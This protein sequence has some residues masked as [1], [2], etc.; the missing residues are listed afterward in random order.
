MHKNNQRSFLP[1]HTKPNALLSGQWDDWLLRIGS[2]DKHVVN[3]GGKR[4]IWGRAHR[5]IEIKANMQRRCFTRVRR[6]VL[7]FRTWHSWP[8]L[9]SYFGWSWAKKLHV[10]SGRCIMC[11]LL[12]WSGSL[13]LLVD[14][15]LVQVFLC[16]NLKQ[17]QVTIEWDD[18]RERMHHVSGNKFMLK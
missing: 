8:L 11:C 7:L 1:K 4:G 9:I 12:Y 2:D 17:T 5:D 14:D 15:N 16:Q 13:N 3:A 10:S 6:S 18:A